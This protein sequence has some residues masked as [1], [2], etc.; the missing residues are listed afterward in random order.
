M[1]TSPSKN[2]E[3]W[4][5]PMESTSRSCL[6]WE[7]NHHH[8]NTRSSS[9]STST[10]KVGVFFGFF[11]MC[12]LTF[13]CYETQ[14]GSSR[15][16]CAPAGFLMPQKFKSPP[17]RSQGRANSAAAGFGRQRSRLASEDNCPLVK[18]WDFRSPFLLQESRT[19][20]LFAL[21][22]SG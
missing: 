9:S 22:N 7:V 4:K 15:N 2:R 12:G 3:V 11:Y 17:P 14:L 18:R 8:V 5:N 1:I 16:P 20:E 10:G 21:E 19:P 13:C 6:F